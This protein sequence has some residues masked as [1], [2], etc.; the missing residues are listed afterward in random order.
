MSQNCRRKTREECE[1]IYISFL[2][3]RWIFDGSWCNVD[4]WSFVNNNMNKTVKVGDWI[5][6]RN[7]SDLVSY[8]GQLGLVG[9]QHIAFITMKQHGIRTFP[10]AWH[11]KPVS[12]ISIYAITE[13]NMK[14]ILGPSHPLHE[15]EIR[16]GKRY[17]NM[18]RYFRE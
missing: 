2:L 14:E 8:S 17:I 6:H 5:R 12:V 7:N 4:N 11:G 13:G 9:V 3:D 10:N 18:D 1:N 15:F 16:V